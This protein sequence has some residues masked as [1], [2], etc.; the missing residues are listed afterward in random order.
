MFNIVDLV[1]KK[2]DHI[3]SVDF[4]SKSTPMLF[5]YEISSPNDKEV[6]ESWFSRMISTGPPILT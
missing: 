5:R 6:V 3:P 2:K 4:N 1:N